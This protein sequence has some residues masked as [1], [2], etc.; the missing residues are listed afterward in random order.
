MQR[1]INSNG[2]LAAKESSQILQSKETNKAQAF[3]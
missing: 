3:E 1:K 2:L